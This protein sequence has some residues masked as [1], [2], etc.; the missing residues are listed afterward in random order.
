MEG[1]SV[2]ATEAVGW[3]IDYAGSMEASLQLV[4]KIANN[5]D[6]VIPQRK[7]EEDKLKDVPTEIAGLAES[8]N[9]ATVA[10]RAA[11][12]ESLRHCCDAT[13]TEALRLQAK[14]SADFMTS[15]HCQNGIIGSEY[16]KTMLV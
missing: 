1:K 10:A 11:I 5:E 15:S 2:K 3:L 7:L 6:G 4:W 14:Y 16:K 9:P 13:L 12:M 8:D